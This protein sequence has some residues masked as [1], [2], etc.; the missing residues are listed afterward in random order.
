MSHNREVLRLI[1]QAISSERADE[2][3]EAA[4][5]TQSRRPQAPDS[6]QLAATIL[7]TLEE[8]GFVIVPEEDINV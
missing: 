2:S 6:E 5:T 4:A 7:R 3:D 8:A 1:V